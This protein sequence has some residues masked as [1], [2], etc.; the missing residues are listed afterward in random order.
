MESLIAIFEEIE[1]PRDYNVRHELPAMLF[2][3]LS[4]TLCGAKS[5]VDIADYA[6]ANQEMLATLF[7]LRHGTPSHDSFSRLFRLLDPSELEAT[8]HRFANAI[9]EGLQLGPPKGVVALDGKR[10]RRGYERGRASM[11]PMLVTIWDSETRLSLGVRGSTD[12]NEVK[13][14][15]EALKAVALKGCTV[16]ADALH[17]HPKLAQEVRSQG[18]D[19]VLKLKA[20]HGPLYRTAEAA[21]AK[22]EAAGTLRPC[23]L[24]EHGHDRD[25]RRSGSMVKA[26]ADAPAFPGLAAF[27][28]IE[29]ERCLAGGEVQRRTHYV[30]MSRVMSAPQM[31]AITR[32]HW[33]IENKLHWPLDVVFFEDDART[34]KNYGPQNFSVVRHMALNLLRAHPDNRSVGRKMKRAAWD[35]TFFYEL[36]TYMR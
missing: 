33:G 16:T 27:G 32:T 5:C 26:P 29:S 22:A 6:E 11:P 12:G 3:A 36:F 1:D 23:V 24:N 18:A 14:A 34:R 2:M 13:A 31:M 21:F 20:N 19:Y 30:V 17:C 15:L 25:E 8:L 35:K 7:D 4:A 9:R 10:L 28:R